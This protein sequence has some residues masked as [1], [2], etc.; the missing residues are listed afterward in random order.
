MSGDGEEC[1]TSTITFRGLMRSISTCSLC[2]L[3]LLIINEL[4]KKLTEEATRKSALHFL[5]A[6][7]IGTICAVIAACLSDK[8]EF[9]RARTWLCTVACL[10]AGVMFFYVWRVRG[11]VDANF[12]IMN[13][14]LPMGRILCDWAGGLSL[15]IIVIWVL[16]LVGVYDL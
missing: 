3:I 10:C 11:A 15:S 14:N 2:A 5:T 7:V 16:L 8:E 1:D 6:P 12:L 4:G 13:T 9:Q